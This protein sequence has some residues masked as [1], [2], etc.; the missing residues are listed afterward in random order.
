MKQQQV[1][2]LDYQGKS[3]HLGE[4]LGRLGYGLRESASS[5]AGLAGLFVDWPAGWGE[6]C[7]DSSPQWRLARAAVE[8][9]VPVFGI[10]HGGNPILHAEDVPWWDGLTAELVHAPGHKR[11]LEMF[12]CPARVVEVGW[13]FCPTA[14]FRSGSVERVLF[15]PTH[16]SV[17]GSYRCDGPRQS[18][19]YQT[20]NQLAF[21]Q[22]LGFPAR[23]KTVRFSGTLEQNGLWRDDRVTRWVKSDL[24]VGSSV[25]DIDRHDLVISD[26]TMLHLAVARGVP[27]VSL[28][29][30]KVV[31]SKGES[32]PHWDEYE[33]WVRY[34]FS[35]DRMGLVE[36]V[37]RASVASDE[38]AGWATDWVGGPLDPAVLAS[39]LN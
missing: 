25:R 20:Q 15:A 31:D 5:L 39:L 9:D 29:L 7:G 16:P 26:G 35:L 36:A 18:D 6:Y 8:Q 17:D 2:V 4:T 23:E 27:A 33:E 28:G 21:E 13:T 12:G 10:P 1:L 37:A 24:T 22:L 14:E 32:F 30:P 34:P 38:L 11:L 3:R 19:D